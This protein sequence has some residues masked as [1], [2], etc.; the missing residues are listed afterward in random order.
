[1][2]E[3]QEENAMEL[4]KNKE[5]LEIVNKTE[6]AMDVIKEEEK[7]PPVTPPS[8]EVEQ[9]IKPLAPLKENNAIDREM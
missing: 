4:A 1:M 9:P 6:P 3:S 5:N 8:K 2:V 7:Q